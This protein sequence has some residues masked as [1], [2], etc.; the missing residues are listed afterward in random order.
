MGLT[1]LY[2][3]VLSVAS[4]AQSDQVLL[5]TFASCASPPSG[6][7]LSCCLRGL[8]FLVLRT[9]QSSYLSSGKPPVAP[10]IFPVLHSYPILVSINPPVDL[11]VHCC[12]PSC[13]RLFPSQIFGSTATREGCP[14]V[15]RQS[16][17][18]KPNVMQPRQAG[19]VSPSTLGTERDAETRIPKEKIT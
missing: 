10:R 11:R 4:A 8:V 15:W 12:C 16:L 13:A 18:P 9:D 1:V 5:C 6:Q 7:L 2:P 17:A 3:A 19:A 14:R